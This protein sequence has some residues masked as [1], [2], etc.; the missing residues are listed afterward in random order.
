MQSQGGEGGSG[1]AARL[2]RLLGYVAADPQNTQLLADAAQEALRLGDAAQARSLI[3]RGL[4]ASAGDTAKRF[5]FGNLLLAAGDYAGAE[6]LFA[7]LA[8][9]IG[10]KPPVVYNIAVA[11]FGEKRYVEAIERLQGIAEAGQ[12]ELPQFELLLAKALYYDQRIEGAL[13]HIDRFLQG[14]PNDREGLQFKS[15]IAYDAGAAVAAEAV[16]RRLLSAYPDD[17]IG[18]LVL[19][20]I[21]VDQRN[22]ELAR[23][24]I[25][26]SLARQPDLGRAW[27]MLGF[28]NLQETRLDVACGDFEHAVQHMTDHLGT[29]HGLA[30][31]R[32]LLGNLPGA[33]E[34]V[35]RAMAV[36]R[37]FSENHG[38]LA[39]LEVLE[40]RFEEAETSIKRGLRLDR[41]SPSS[42]YAR[43]LL[44][45]ERGEPGASKK[46]IERIL[47]QA[48][49]ADAERI[50][51][52]A[53]GFRPGK[54]PQRG[55]SS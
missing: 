1:D 24:H 10:P 13:E 4:G 20:S 30:W 3:E 33:H 48:G 28:A 35:N 50:A 46:L 9:E 16:A 8:D 7:G 18:H 52:L 51:E 12:R 34:A 17:A 49:I 39:V 40:G 26:Q 29:W 14:A 45:A 41:K 11:L 32:L 22:P 31:A 38:T 43:S 15:L 19:G 36:D 54:M 21:A 23:Q 55:S 37:N 2:Q 42:N 47:T 6:G 25:Q 53:V 27:S 5:H 44:M